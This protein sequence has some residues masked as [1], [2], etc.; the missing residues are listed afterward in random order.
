MSKYWNTSGLGNPDW[1]WATLKQNPEG[2]LLLAAGGALLLR[3]G[4]SR[5]GTQHDSEHVQDCQAHRESMADHMPYQSRVADRANEASGSAEKAREHASLLGKNETARDYAAAASEYAHATREKVVEQSRR[6]TDIAQIRVQSL[7]REHPLAVALAGLAAGAAVAAALPATTPERR[8]LGPARQRL[9]EAAET[10]GE[11]I[12]EA[13]LA[14]GERLKGGVEHAVGAGLK[15]AA[16]TPA[17]GIAGEQKSPDLGARAAGS[18]AAESGTDQLKSDSKLEGKECSKEA[19]AAK[20]ILDAQ[21]KAVDDIRAGRPA[22]YYFTAPQ[23]SVPSRDTAPSS[24]NDP[25]PKNK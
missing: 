14:A 12:S 15:E 19:K 1:L 25:H 10:A 8:V 20:A 13:S 9:Y 24:I 16:G 18:F 21:Q 11:K 4:S 2:L 5:P 3:R 23:S 6:L 7:V 17:S 22:P